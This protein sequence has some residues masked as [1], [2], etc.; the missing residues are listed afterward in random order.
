MPVYFSGNTKILRVWA[1]KLPRDFQCVAPIPELFDLFIKERTHLAIVVDQ[2]GNTIGL[3]TMEDII[4]TLLGLEIMDESDNIEDM[5]LLAR[6]NWE[7]RAKKLGILKS[8]ENE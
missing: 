1:V 4:E 7:K 6:K 8:E 5:Q 3:V 2:Y